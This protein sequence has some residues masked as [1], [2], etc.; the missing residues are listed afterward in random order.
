VTIDAYLTELERLLSWSARRRALPEIKEH[1]RDSAAR[2]RDTGE[3][4]FEAEEVATRDFGRAAEVARRVDGELAVR[5][6]RLAS[7]LALGAVLA[8]VGP[9]YVIP[10]NSLGPATWTEV[11]AEILGL[12]RVSIALWLVSG[13][14]AAVSVA[15]SWT[16]RLDV[17]AHTLLATAGSI[18]AATAVGSAL[19]LRWIQLS[20]TTPNWALSALFAALI[21]AVCAL[22]ALWTRST[23]RRILAA[24]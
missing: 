21:L 9:L 20:P 7:L 1:L 24:A 6:T 4:P 17:A 15:L 14:L 18:V 11:P 8:F 10:E 12:Q 13:T 16:R 23:R 22:A 2:H 19:A 3:S 5:E